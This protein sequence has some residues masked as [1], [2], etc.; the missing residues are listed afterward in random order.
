MNIIVSLSKVPQ[1]LKK[2]T[3]I[4]SVEGTT[5]KQKNTMEKQKG[6]LALNQSNIMCWTRGKRI[7]IN[8]GCQKECDE[9][10]F[11]ISYRMMHN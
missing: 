6:T 11:V 7:L 1:K 8:N 4:K 10:K 5:K 9:S 2:S 3:A